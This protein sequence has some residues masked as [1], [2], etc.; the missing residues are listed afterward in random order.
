M[1]RPDRYRRSSSL[2]LYWDEGRLVAH[3]YRSGERFVVDPVL[4]P[5][6]HAYPEIEAPESVVSQ[7]ARH[8]LLEPRARDKKRT[9]V[10]W[11]D[12]G[13]LA[14][15]FHFGTKDVPWSAN[16]RRGERRL[17]L[18]ARH[19]PMPAATKNAP[20]GAKLTPLPAVQPGGQFVETLLGRRTWRDFGRAKVTL[21][22]IATLLH[23]TWG[24]QRWGIVRGQGR[25]AL[26]TSPSG[27]ACH[28]GEVYL[29]AV[30]VDGLRPGLYHYQCD[31]HRLALVRNGATSADIGRYI[32]G[33][34]WYRPAAA[35]FLM[36]AVFARE[37]WRYATPRAYR[38]LLADAGHLC[39]TF[40][41]TATWLKLAPFCSMA[42]ADSVIERDLGID[43]VSE[44][45]LYIAGVGTRPTGG[46]RP[47]VPGLRQ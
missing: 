21:K 2:I 10:G 32:P 25:V 15:A 24:V 33:Q 14:A 5:F 17:R 38:T 9:A 34:R 3:N 13:A 30:R 39:Q 41:L 12:W 20:R 45:A 6:L 36:T 23:L 7:L 11:H 1:A 27:G 31:R 8:R 26:K 37:Q 40:C 35:L 43:G 19:T 16:P 42:L 18:R 28:P 46:W 29:L 44:G 47:G 22:D 4:V